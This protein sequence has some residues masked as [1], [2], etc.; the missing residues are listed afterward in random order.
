MQILQTPI[1]QTAIPELATLTSERHTLIE[2]SR[3]LGIPFDALLDQLW[4]SEVTEYRAAALISLAQQQ[5]ASEFAA[6]EQAK[7]QRAARRMGRR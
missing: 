7:Q 3:H 5:I 4:S 1:H 6:K 2:L